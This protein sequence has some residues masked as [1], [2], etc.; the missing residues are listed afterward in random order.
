MRR[1]L[2]HSRQRRFGTSFTAPHLF[3]LPSV[4][5]AYVQGSCNCICLP[6]PPAPSNSGP[7]IRRMASRHGNYV[8]NPS[9]DQR[10]QA[11]VRSAPLQQC[12]CTV[13][14]PDRIDQGS[15]D[16]RCDVWM[17]TTDLTRGKCLFCIPGHHTPPFKKP[18]LHP[19]DSPSRK[20]ARSP[21]SE[22]PVDDSGARGSGETK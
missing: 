14:G 17:L 7:Y 5:M 18:T 9:V 10:L 21:S 15:T 6:R 8:V 12:N 1:T 13:C 4:S 20:R 2:I 16:T 11:I 3:A 19:E 22:N